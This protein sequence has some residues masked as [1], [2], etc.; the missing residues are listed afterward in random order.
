MPEPCNV[1]TL[2]SFLG[3]INFYGKCVNNMHEI[4][5]PLD[6]LL[7]SKTPWEWNSKRRNS[8]M[9]LKEVIMSDLLLTHYDPNRKIIVAADASNYGLGAC[10]FHEFEDGRIKAISH[11]SRSLTPAEKSYSQIE[12]EALALIFATTKFHKMIFGRKF[13]LK[14]NCPNCRNY[15]SFKHQTENFLYFHIHNILIKIPTY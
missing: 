2:R 10:I 15:K 11:A 5:G 13:I 9:N 4:R 7:K 6:E 12:K 8:F 14:T 1:S 3:A